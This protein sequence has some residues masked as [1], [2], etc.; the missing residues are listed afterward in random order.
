MNAYRRAM[1][2]VEILVAIAVIGILVAITI[3]A[4]QAA[5]EMARK[6]TCQNHL[7][8]IGMAAQ[9]HHDSV[10]H[11]PSGGWGFRWLGDP[12]RGFG[13]SQPGGWI[14]N[15]LPYLEQGSLREIGSGAD[16]AVKRAELKRLAAIPIALLHCPSRRLPGAL[17]YL[18]KAQLVNAD[19]PTLAAKCDY[20]AS[21]GS[22]SYD[23]RAGGPP[24]LDPATV[25][26]YDW[27]DTSRANGVIYLRSQTRMSDIV[28]GT[29]QTYLVGEKNVSIRAGTTHED[30]DPGDDQTPYVGDDRDIRRWTA[31]IP[32]QDSEGRAPTVFGSAHGAGCYFVFCDGAVRLIR[33]TVDPDVHARLGSRADRTS[34]DLSGL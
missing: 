1:T 3:P 12:D 23:H 16:Q 22:V 33:Y 13:E 30:R 15:L 4:V 14:Y 10:G 8:Q 28:D 25:A 2:L 19:Q 18:G 26:A 7:R 9:M 11:L 29:G 24:S 5:R 20:A 17:P 6:T 27:P 34:V 32:R 21:G 31:E